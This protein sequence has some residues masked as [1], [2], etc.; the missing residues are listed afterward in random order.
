[1]YCLRKTSALTS[2]DDNDDHQNDLDVL[3]DATIDELKSIEKL[4]MKSILIK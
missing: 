3:N 1:M 2:D 4:E